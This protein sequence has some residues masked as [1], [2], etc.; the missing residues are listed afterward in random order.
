VNA[1]ADAASGQ[2]RDGRYA[3][4]VYSGV[5]YLQCSNPSLEDYFTSS[6]LSSGLTAEPLGL[7]K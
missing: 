5:Q 2:E 4:T 3:G 1:A 6:E 7:S